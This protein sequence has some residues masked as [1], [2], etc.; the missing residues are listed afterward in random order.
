M[1][2]EVSRKQSVSACAAT[3]GFA[4]FC[5][6]LKQD[7]SRKTPS[8]GLKLVDQD[9]RRLAASRAAFD[10]AQ[11]AEGGKTPES[12]AKAAAL[13]AECIAARGTLRLPWSNW[14]AA[15]SA[16]ANGAALLLKLGDLELAREC[17]PEAPPDV[18][19]YA[20]IVSCCTSLMGCA[21]CGRVRCRYATTLLSEQPQHLQ[22]LGSAAKSWSRAGDYK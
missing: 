1:P 17:A 4:L 20:S 11:K 16:K 9:E 5:V 10:R 7:C 13:Y 2:S 14:N 22:A 3:L 8:V 18:Q 12:D 6:S 15:N 21:V 19:R